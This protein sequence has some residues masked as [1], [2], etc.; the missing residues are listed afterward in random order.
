[1][2]EV[3]QLRLK[4]IKSGLQTET[5]STKINN[6]SY[7]EKME[8]LKHRITETHKRHNNQV[9]ISNLAKVRQ[10]DV[11]SLVDG[12]QPPHPDWLLAK[13]N[14]VPDFASQGRL[15]TFAQYND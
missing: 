11:Q 1:M 14:F 2:Q 9:N 4:S 8:N 12:R 3:A 10:Q 15:I 5:S 6:M 7:F 13:T